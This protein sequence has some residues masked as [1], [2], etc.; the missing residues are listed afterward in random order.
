MR[1]SSNRPYTAGD[2]SAPVAFVLTNARLTSAIG[3]GRAPSA[4]RPITITES[5]TIEALAGLSSAHEIA[6]AN[7]AASGAPSI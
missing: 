7:E 6:R 1:S 3:P 2:Q 5:P 4:T